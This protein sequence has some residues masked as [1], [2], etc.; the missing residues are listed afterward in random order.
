MNDGKR[1]NAFE[2][3]LMEYNM[4]SFDSKLKNIWQ[5]FLKTHNENYQFQYF[6][7]SQR[8]N[9]IIQWLNSFFV[10]FELKVFKQTHAYTSWALQV[11]FVSLLGCIHIFFLLFCYLKVVFQHFY[12]Y[13]FWHLNFQSNYRSFKFQII[14]LHYRF[15]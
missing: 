15:F 13:F 11:V 6:Y 10:L 12:H 1:K 3:R 2:S 8:L 7:K 14:F 5:D 4:F 9:L